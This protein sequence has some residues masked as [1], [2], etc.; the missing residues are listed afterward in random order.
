M[1]KQDTGSLWPF[2]GGEQAVHARLGITKQVAMYDRFIRRA[3]PDQHRTFF[4]DL[5][6]VIIG[7]VD[8]QGF[9]WA[10]PVFDPYQ[11]KGL[12]HQQFIDSPSSTRLVVNALP[13][14]AKALGVSLEQNDRVG[15]LGIQLST[16]RRNR[17]NGVVSQRD[18]GG[19]ELEVDQSFGNCPK[20]IQVRDLQWRDDIPLLV[21]PDTSEVRPDLLS[22][23]AREFIELA[24][25]FFI[26]SRSEDLTQD[27]RH[28]VDVSH[29]GGK[30]G[31]VK[32]G[33]NKLVFPDYSGNKFFNTVGNIEADGRVGLF[34]PDF[35]GSNALYLS[36]RAE[37]VWEGAEVTG[38]KG[39]ERLISVTVERWALLEDHLPMQGEIQEFSP[40]LKM[41]GHWSEV[42]VW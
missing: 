5:P 29:R 21:S 9:P 20:Y 39:A 36:G 12:S 33:A 32:V 7:A 6:Y 11:G 10:M 16:R 25:T 14:V 15:V 28:G 19:F 3:M 27:A 30:P 23:R 8:E 37:I 41:T 13:P 34:F 22:E 40:H 4:S 24:D 18:D 42:A 38:F 1:N 31:F 26:A 17:M 2:H 35:A